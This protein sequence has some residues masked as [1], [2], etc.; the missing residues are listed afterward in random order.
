MKL[1][2]AV[3]VLLA[4]YASAL[5]GVNIKLSNRL[6][7]LTVGP[8]DNYQGV[9]G[10]DH[11]LFFTRSVN[12]V[13]LL[14]QQGLK[15]EETLVIDDSANSKDPELSP[16]GKQ[17]AFT[18]F[19][20]D[21]KGD[22]CLTDVGDKDHTVRCVTSRDSYVLSPFWF[23]AGELGYLTRKTLGE[24]WKLVRHN[25]KTGE[26]KAVVSGDLATPTA[27]QS[28]AWLAY[29][30]FDK[31][32]A[33][34]ELWIRHGASEPSLVAW[35]LPGVTGFV[36]FSPDDQFIYFS[37]YLS[38]TNFDRMI[39]ASDNSVI[40]RFPLNQIKPGSEA[41][42][43]EQL[44]SVES[45]CN[46]PYPT[47]EDLLVTC[48]FEGTLDVYSLN[49]EGTVPQ[50]WKYDDLWRGHAASRTYEERLLYL[51]TL[52]YRFP[53]KV[54]VR[55]VTERVLSNHIQIGETTAA[56]FYIDRL[57][58]MEP[59]ESERA[60]YKLLRLY[61]DGLEAKLGEPL[62][63]LT[64][65]FQHKIE[66]LGSQVAA[67]S[68]HPKL[69]SVIAA[70]F[71]D[72]LGN[73]D[74]ARSQLAK[75]NWTEPF[76]PL[77]RYLGI[78]L[79]TKLEKGKEARLLPQYEAA[80]R[81]PQQTAEAKLFYAFNYLGL[82]D[83]IHGDDLTTRTKAIQAFMPKLGAQESAVTTLLDFEIRSYDLA[84]APEKGEKDAYKVLGKIMETNK[85]DYF[86]RKAFFIRTILNMGRANKFYYL[87][88]IASD[89]LRYTDLEDAEAGYALAQ[90]SYATMDKAFD[91]FAKGNYKNAGDIFYLA[92]RQTDDLQA[93]YGMTVTRD[94]QGRRDKLAD[95]Y[96]DLVKRKLTGQNA[97]YQQ[98]LLQILD[99]NRNKDPKALEQPLNLLN[100][101][102]VEGANPGMR[103]QL[104]GY[105]YHRQL[106][107]T[108]DR[109]DYD[110]ALFKQAHRHYVL[111]LTMGYDDFRSKAAVL[112]DLAHLHQEVGNHDIASAYFRKREELPYLNPEQELGRRWALARSLF[113]SHRPEESLLE[114]EAAL[115]VATNEADKVAFTERAAFYAVYAENYAK[116]HAYY[117]TLLARADFKAQRLNYA[118]A[119][120]GDGYAL[121]KLKKLAEAK[122]ILVQAIA[123]ARELKPIPVDAQRLVAFRPERIEMIANGLLAQNLTD[124]NEQIAF[125]EARI[126]LFEK[127][128][129]E[130]ESYATSR[131]IWSQDLG[132]DLVQLALLREK[133]NEPAKTAELLARALT[134]SSEGSPIDPIGYRTFID[135]FALGLAHPK[136]FR[137]NPDKP[138]RERMELALKEY[139]DIHKI[140]APQVYQKLQLELFWTAYRNRVLGEAMDLPAALKAILDRDEAQILAQQSPERYA[141]LRGMGKNL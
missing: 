77:E 7:K 28:G 118:K 103:Q 57:I 105:V 22:I 132:K 141:L 30:T 34:W 122:T 49:K 71:A 99:F 73:T 121:L 72:F 78:G 89:W 110:V 17:L 41:L 126:R 69:K 111:A 106:Q 11:T 46:F 1:I 81:D 54:D 135:Y 9:M 128:E 14:Y 119:L 138:V 109:Y 2:Q 63:R 55:D 16:D 13:T 18:Y 95:D 139:K 10:D 12:L 127:S 64:A 56:K 134:I 80:I 140:E 67:I 44:T 116:A 65:A 104:L 76:R 24:P 5:Y 98:A 91:L 66:T 68:A 3:T 52:R 39:D 70:Y 45:N 43:P 87:E 20:F 83:Q 29:N 8:Y 107:A 50:T 96:A 27:S 136:E 25:L 86:L 21:S 31:T 92:V 94:L 79:W 74:S 82:L 114:M 133:A 19:K 15:G 100:A 115:K 33:K 23:S 123:V 131:S 125:K 6:H 4:T 58:A 101:M 47:K 120:L 48:A 117:T 60:Y 88:T 62:G 75:L 102:D 26:T 36:R 37:Q 137:A 85:K 35:D 38:D 113:Y 129:K 90:F 51:N 84:R 42:L 112:D 61:I 93:H 53:Q 59:T 130:M 124:V 32:K 40:F 108:K 97:N